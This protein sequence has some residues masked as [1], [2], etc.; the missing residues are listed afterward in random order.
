M[1][2]EADSLSCALLPVTALETTSTLI[3]P[4]VLHS[5]RLCTIAVVLA[6]RG[7]F[8]LIGCTL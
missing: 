4:Q 7:H 8:R 3:S 2:I 5:L 6:V 1:E